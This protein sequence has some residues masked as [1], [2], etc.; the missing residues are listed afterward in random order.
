[1]SVNAKP[2]FGQELAQSNGLADS[3]F[4]ELSDLTAELTGIQL[5][6]SKKTMLFARISR[7]MRALNLTTCAQYVAELRNPASAERPLFINSVTTN[8]T[9]FFREDFHFDLLAKTA[10]P[11]VRE[12]KAANDV[13]RLWSAGCSS[14]EEPFTLAITLAE[15][16]LAGDDDYR[17]LA[18]D[19]DSDMVAR[20]TAG[21]F[22]ADNV[23]GLSDDRRRR[24]FMERDGM[25]IAADQL[26]QGMIV[27]Q[28]NLFRSW[29]I[30]NGVD[31]IFCRNVMIYF[32]KDDQTRLIQKF[33]RVQ[34]PGA[35][36]FLGHSESIR[37]QEDAYKR[38]ANTVY[39]RQ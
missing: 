1:M 39:Q 19:L 12:R 32:N 30:K 34:E 29:P 6:K 24:W 25:L 7:R 28:L 31:V 9:Y 17:L 20:T 10:W 27:K 37:G 23:R 38:V 33:A 2:S 14:G 35:Y 18:T 15:L 4:D 21:E 22:N 16:G 13:V 36:L 5:D 3:E 26:R 11:D 8:L